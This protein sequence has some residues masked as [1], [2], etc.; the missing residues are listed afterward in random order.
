MEGIGR[1]A[2]M[3]FRIGERARDLEGELDYTVNLASHGSSAAAARPDWAN[4][5]M[6]EVGWAG[7]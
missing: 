2:A 6:E 7:R 5:R 4:E 1:L 3:R